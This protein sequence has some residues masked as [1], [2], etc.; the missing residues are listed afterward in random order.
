MARAK[1]FPWD[2]GFRPNWRGSA[3]HLVPAEQLLMY[4]YLDTVHPTPDE[5]WYDVPMD[6]ADPRI[7]QY[8]DAR[9][10]LNP[11]EMRIWYT[12]TARRAD[13]IQRA[14][15]E[16][17]VVE[18]RDRAGMQTI[19]EA[20]SYSQHA[21][22]EWPYLNWAAPLVISRIYERGI[23]DTMSQLGIETLSAPGDLYDPAKI[24]SRYVPG[25]DEI[26]G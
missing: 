8:T 2:E 5:I 20:T 18:L 22:A 9:Q 24:A 17:R 4:W 26:P 14:G 12:L 19:G 13:A 16:Y 10:I 11:T 15:A 6:G 1:T 7:A 3:P 25:P 21:R 23:R